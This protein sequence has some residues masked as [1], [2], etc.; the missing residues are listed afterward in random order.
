MRLEFVV[1]TCSH[2][3]MGSLVW[4]GMQVFQIK[5][6]ELDSLKVTQKEFVQ[7]IEDLKAKVFT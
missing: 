5:M 6:K 1:V 4:L 3:E 7:R 2:C